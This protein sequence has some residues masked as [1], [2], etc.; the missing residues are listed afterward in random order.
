[1]FHSFQN[2][3][4]VFF[5]NPPLPKRYQWCFSYL[6]SL[7]SQSLESWHAY[8]NKPHIAKGCHLQFAQ[9]SCKFLL[10]LHCCIFCAAICCSHRIEG[11]LDES[12]RIFYTECM[13]M[14]F[15][16]RIFDK[17]LQCKWMNEKKL[18][19]VGY[20][21]VHPNES[22]I[23]ILI[24]W[25]VYANVVYFFCYS[26]LSCWCEKLKEKNHTCLALGTNYQLLLRNSQEPALFNQKVNAE[27]VWCSTGKSCVI[28][29]IHSDSMAF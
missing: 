25:L 3:K 1:M 12:L 20:I 14:P 22:R 2:D 6:H 10:K 4:F 27:G 19:R 29:Q 17:G 23:E 28:K 15:S 7:C 26:K 8:W 9:L 21:Y 18:C 5:H 16:L 11:L 13:S 24:I